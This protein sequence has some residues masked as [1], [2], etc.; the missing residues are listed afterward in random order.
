MSVPKTHPDKNKLF[1][2]DFQVDRL[3]HYLSTEGG[4]I[5]LRE[6]QRVHTQAGEEEHF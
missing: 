4:P 2:E 6:E 5:V 3:R 1:P